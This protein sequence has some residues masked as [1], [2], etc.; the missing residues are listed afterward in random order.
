MKTKI[1]LATQN[2]GKI[3]R[4]KKL[5]KHTGLDIE[6][7]TPKDFGLEN[8]NPEENGKTLAE[9]AIIKARAYLGKVDMPILANDTG[10]WIEGE[11]LIDAPKRKALGENNEKQLTKEEAAKGLLNFWKGVATK[12]GGKVD[13]AW[14]EAFA[15]IHHDGSIKKADSRRE[16]ILT[17][18]EFGKAHLQMPVRALY[19]SK[20]T[21]K[22]AIQHT[23]EE[24]ILEMKPVIDALT[25]VLKI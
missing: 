9:N 6:V 7:H 12:Q 20:A 25:K 3:E 1:L 23:A 24:E 2:E 11:G 15:V 5:L 17:D 13:A 19:I 4:F 16:V 14:V 22:P 18:Q 10:F 21:N 8:I